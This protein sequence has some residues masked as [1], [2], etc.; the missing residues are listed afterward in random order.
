MNKDDQLK[1]LNMLFPDNI[2]IEIMYTYSKVYNSSKG[3]GNQ[4]NK[5][6]YYKTENNKSY[7]RKTV[8]KWIDRYNAN[9]NIFSV[10]KYSEIIQRFL[11]L[12]PVPKEF[13]KNI[14]KNDNEEINANENYNEIFNG[15]SYDKNYSNAKIWDYHLLNASIYFAYESIYIDSIILNC[16]ES[17]LKKELQN[18]N[19]Y[20]ISEEEISNYKENYI[21]LNCKMTYVR[22]STDWPM[23]VTHENKEYYNMRSMLYTNN[24][25]FIYNCEFDIARYEKITK[26]RKKIKLISDILKEEKKNIELLS[27]N[28]IERIKSKCDD[29]EQRDCLVTLEPSEWSVKIV[30]AISIIKIKNNKNE[31]IRVKVGLN[32]N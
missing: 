7:N 16:S 18:F 32:I 8:Y 30:D 14:I 23:N 2:G 20:F 29:Y 15:E 11:Q 21:Y 27:K 26:R 22:E 5:I 25:S 31:T 6:D 1:E 28:I 19:L 24:E 17:T 4:A 10:L 3:E 9:Y 12:Y 13:Y